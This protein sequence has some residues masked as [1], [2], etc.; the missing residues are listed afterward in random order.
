MTPLVIAWESAPAGVSV[1]FTTRLG[2]ASGGPYE[3]LNLGAL[4]GDSA[5]AVRENR[6]G[7]WMPWAPIRRQPPWP[8]RS[9]ARTCAR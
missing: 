9:P 6:G 1:A 2:G 5:E 7:R 4:T 3:S 8:G